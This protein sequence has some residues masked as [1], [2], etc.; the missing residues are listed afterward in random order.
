MTGFVERSSGLERR[1]AKLPAR[2]VTRMELATLREVC[3][4]RKGESKSNSSFS[5]YTARNR[6]AKQEEKRGQ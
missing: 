5:A 2:D 6:I 1:A 4:V 3:G